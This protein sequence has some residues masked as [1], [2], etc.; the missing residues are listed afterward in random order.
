MLEVGP[1]RERLT[2]SG[3]QLDL[4]RGVTAFGDPSKPPAMQR[5]DVA[6]SVER[7]LWCRILRARLLR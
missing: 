5:P 1:K 3:H 6:V 4:G 7:G 2:F